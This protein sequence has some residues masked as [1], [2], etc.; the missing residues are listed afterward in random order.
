M[1]N[2]DVKN[3]K[4]LPRIR[5]EIQLNDPIS[6]RGLRLQL[7]DMLQ[8]QNVID[9][10]EQQEQRNIINDDRIKKNEQID[11]GYKN[12]IKKVEVQKWAKQML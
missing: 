2:N 4:K 7:I 9:E 3:C 8:I 6:Q 5:R 1:F 10:V 12:H 11:E